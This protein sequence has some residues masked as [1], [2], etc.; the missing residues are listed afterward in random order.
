MSVCFYYSAVLVFFLHGYMQIY[1]WVG[2][3]PYY[4]FA[5]RRKLNVG[6]C[7]VTTMAEDSQ[8]CFA[9]SPR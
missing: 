3:C 1:E 2:R 6:I 5:S 7:E 9:I 4:V 8:P